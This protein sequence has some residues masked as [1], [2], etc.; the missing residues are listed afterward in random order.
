MTA[1]EL[2]A[3]YNQLDEAG[4]RQVDQ[5]VEAMLQPTAEQE[6]WHRLSAEMLNRAYGADEPEY[7]ESNLRERNTVFQP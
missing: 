7:T 3:R 2:L 1:E 6:S 5:L 4:K